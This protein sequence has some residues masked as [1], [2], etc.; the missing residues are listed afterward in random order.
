MNAPSD[1]VT[2][3]RANVGQLLSTRERLRAL[4]RVMAANPK[5]LDDPKAFA[6]DNSDLTADIVATAAK[7]LDALDKMVAPEQ[8]TTLFTVAGTL[9][10]PK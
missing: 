1:F 5:L 4:Q 6:G 7:E 3:F 10:F 2:I 9:A 8:E